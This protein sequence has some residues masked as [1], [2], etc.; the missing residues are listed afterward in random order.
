MKLIEE[1][2][3]LKRLDITIQIIENSFL[4]YFYQIFN[5]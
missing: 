2:K 5:P 1:R 3:V 4:V